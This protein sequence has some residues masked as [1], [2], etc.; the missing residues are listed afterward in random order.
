MGTKTKISRL[1]NDSL[2][3]LIVRIT[4]SIDNCAIAEVKTADYYTHCV[5]ICER[6]RAANTK[7]EKKKFENI[8]IEFIRRKEIYMET[9]KYLQGLLISPDAATKTSAQKLYAEIDRFG[10]R[11]FNRRKADQAYIYKQ[12][13]AGLNKAELATD[14]EALKLTNQLQQLEVAHRTYEISYMQWGDFKNA[15]IMASKLRSEVEVAIKN[16]LDEIDWL[17][18][19]NP[20]E[21][22]KNLRDSIYTRIDEIN[23]AKSKNKVTP[24]DTTD[25]VSAA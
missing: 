15:A 1:S 14:V 3:T 13:I 5:A 22:L 25:N 8:D 6:Y 21:E 16:L 10:S 19:K 24:T 17:Y 11:F 12:I 23:L 9:R 7:N 18:K 4:N 20:S 2:G